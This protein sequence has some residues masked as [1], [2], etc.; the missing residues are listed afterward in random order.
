MF[1]LIV[2]VKRDPALTV[3]AN[4]FPGFYSA[5]RLI[6]ELLLTRSCWGKKGRGE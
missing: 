3:T 4:R 1:G 5:Q 2:D 6:P